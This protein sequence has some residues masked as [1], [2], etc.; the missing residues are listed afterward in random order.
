[1]GLYVF[2]VRRKERRELN[3]DRTYKE[4]VEMKKCCGKQRGDF[5]KEILDTLDEVVRGTPELG[6]FIEPIKQTIR[7]LRDR[8]VP[9]KGSTEAG[10]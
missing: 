7:A 3:N 5:A 9:S 4:A 2:H 8:K 6:V 10:E 1:M